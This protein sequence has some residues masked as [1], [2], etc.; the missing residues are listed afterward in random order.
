MGVAGDPEDKAAHSYLFVL[1][2]SV[3]GPEK[4]PVKATASLTHMQLCSH[5]QLMWLAHG[6]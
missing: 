6:F 2:N 1:H 3:A 4:K 5:A